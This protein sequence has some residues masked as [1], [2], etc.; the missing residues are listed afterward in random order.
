MI[1]LAISVVY[2]ANQVHANGT[3]NNDLLPVPPATTM[4]TIFLVLLLLYLKD[5]DILSFVQDFVDGV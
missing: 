3:P 5:P 4:R 2:L 1:S